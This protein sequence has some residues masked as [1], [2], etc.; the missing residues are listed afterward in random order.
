MTRLQRECLAASLVAHTGLLF[1]LALSSGFTAPKPVETEVVQLLN[2]V[3][4]VLV[5]APVMGGGTPPASP[6]P[7][8]SQPI[9][10][11]PVQ[12]P[13]KQPEPKRVEAPRRIEKAPE[14]PKTSP[15]GEKPAPAPKRQIEVNL[16]PV[17]RSTTKAETDRARAEADA[18]RR[19]EAEAARL[20]QARQSQ[21][22]SAVGNLSRTL[23][24]STS[25]SVP[26]TGGATY[27]SYTSYVDLIYRQAWAPH[28]PRETGDRS[29]S[30]I[31][32]VVI[33]RNGDVLVSEIKRR[34]GNE[35]LDRSVRVTL[36]RVRTIGRPF[37]EGA[38]DDQREFLIEFNLESRP[39]AG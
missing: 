33:A 19:A 6:P 2:F 38:T 11:P 9:A 22:A 26:G 34:S 8:P 16:K 13:P 5:D 21:F 17:E 37:P 35:A 29:L 28:K 20:A 31:A 23:S 30:V 24:S 4:D 10:L 12:P 25:V 1:L 14:P 7:A 27:A 36:D 39:G 15:T 3:P 18:R 32:R